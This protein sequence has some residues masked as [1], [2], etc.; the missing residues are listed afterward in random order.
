MKKWKKLGVIAVAILGLAS[1]ALLNVKKSSSV[2]INEV[3]T[4]N[5]SLGINEGYIGADYIELYNTSSNEI[6]LNG[7][8]LSDDMSDPKMSCLPGVYIAPK[9]RVV[10]YATGEAKNENELNF[11]LSSKGEK[12]YL[13][14]VDG[15]IMDKVYIPELEQDI[16][17]ARIEDGASK[18]DI[19]EATVGR[20]NG[21]AKIIDT[22]Y[23]T[24][25]IFSH[26]SGYYDDEFFLTISANKNETI[27]YTTDGSEPTVESNIY[28]DGIWV[29][30]PTNQ[31]NVLNNIQNVVPDWKDYRVLE[32]KL[33]KLQ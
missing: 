16:A 24:E 22:N 5:G 2:V 9:D 25:P 17:Y 13:C 31:E 21:E 19:C 6:S 18:W 32:K 33:I 3:C 1:I 12:L 26:E 29:K 10:L 28:K 27:Y 30:N 7:W 23:L 15:M 11:R 20:S 8:Y 14:N 4:R